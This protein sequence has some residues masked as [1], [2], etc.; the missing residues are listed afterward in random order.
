MSFST[1]YLVFM[2]ILHY[3]KGVGS[4]ACIIPSYFP[5]ILGGVLAKFPTPSTTGLL[6]LLFIFVPC[7][8]ACWPIGFITSFHGLPHSKSNHSEEEGVSRDLDSE[9]APLIG[10]WYN[11]HSYFLVVPCDCSPPPPGHVRLSLE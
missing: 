2:L 1:V 6:L 11:T 9:C 10:L 3:M 4:W 8:W 7:L 5:M